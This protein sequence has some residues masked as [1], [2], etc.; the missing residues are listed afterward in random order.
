MS[1]IYEGIKPFSYYAIF[2]STLIIR[3][4][5]YQ[6]EDIQSAASE[7]KYYQTPEGYPDPPENVVIKPVSS[8]SVNISWQAPEHPNGIIEQYVITIVHHR[9]NKKKLID[10]RPYCNDNYKIKPEQAKTIEIEVGK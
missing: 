1:L 7:I 8:S 10:Q 3:D 9:V 2:V 5:N 4:T 6:S